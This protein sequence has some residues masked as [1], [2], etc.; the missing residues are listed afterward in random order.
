MTFF[1]AAKSPTKQQHGLLHTTTPL[2]YCLPPDNAPLRQEQKQQQQHQMAQQ[3]FSQQQSSS[4][5]TKTTK[6]MSS[7]S[8]QKEVHTVDA[9]SEPM[10]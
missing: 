3:H 7:S 4:T 2:S 8:H 6:M 5:T 9:R 1:R 10:P